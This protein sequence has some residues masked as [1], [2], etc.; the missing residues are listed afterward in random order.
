MII[1]KTPFRISFFGGGTDYPSYYLE[2]GGAVIGTTIDKFCYLSCRYLPPFFEHKSRIV[3]SEQEEVARNEEISHP[4]IRAALSFCNIND[5]VEIH[6][7]GD[8]P[9]RSGLG[10][11]SACT[12]G[13]LNA[14]YA[15][16]GR[17][18]TNLQL[19]KN[20]IEI[21]QNILKENVGSQDQIFAAYGGA[22]KIIFNT[23]ATFDIVPLTLKK[24]RM[25]LLQSKLIFCFT[26]VTRIASNVAKSILENIPKKTHDLQEMRKMVD[27]AEDILYTKD[28]DDF[29]RLLHE[30]W[31][32]K[33]SISSNV[34]NDYLDSIYET[35]RKNG[36]IGG[37][38]VGAGGGGFMLFYV[39][40]EY[41]Q[42]VKNALSNV[43]W[44]PISFEKNG[45]K[46]IYY[47]E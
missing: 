36:A 41:Q 14:L 44:V 9:A 29:G 31:M 39:P 12:V 4:P 45:S 6:H 43:V 22:N 26:K 25:N 23:D 10:S 32:I 24:E 40:E 19:A 47:S 38:I 2:H 30:S 13:I 17:R 21:E 28:I 16:L 7:D 8:L 11:S 15:I 42:N 46:I 33:R 37:K 3:Y 5:G 20:A 18:V 27:I 34:S 35:A 1:S